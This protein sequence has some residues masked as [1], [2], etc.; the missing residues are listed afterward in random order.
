MTRDDETP[1]D[2]LLRSVIDELKRPAP[3]RRDLRDRVLADIRAPRG[4]RVLQWLRQPLA[5][6]LTPLGLLTEVAAVASLVFLVRSPTPPVAEAPAVTLAYYAPAA[7]QVSV[8]GDFN[9][10]D[11][12]ATPLRASKQRDGLWT[13]DLTL[14]PGR[15][16]Y[17]FVIDGDEW[18]T[19]PAAPVATDGEFGTPN[20]TLTV[21]GS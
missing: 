9:D 1:P 15:H 19:D 6:R 13:V 7:R 2:R 10:W 4:P 21:T 14:A 3:L 16:E 17:A 11:A 18:V 12:H 8:V 5:V 20:S